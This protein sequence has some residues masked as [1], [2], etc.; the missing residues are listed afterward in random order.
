MVA[1]YAMEKDVPFY[2]CSN[3]SSFSLDDFL[4]IL[5]LPLVIMLVLQLVFFCTMANEVYHL[6]SAGKESKKGEKK[7]IQK[8]ERAWPLTDCFYS[9]MLS[10][11]IQAHM[12][13]DFFTSSRY[14]FL[15]SSIL[16]DL[17]QSELALE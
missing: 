1:I 13:I 11:Y 6:S 12:M 8:K 5:V 4:F 16:S 7:K 10:Q 14:K 15:N 9:Y 17:F 2:W 3:P